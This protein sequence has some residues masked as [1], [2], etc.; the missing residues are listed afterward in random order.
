MAVGPYFNAQKGE[1]LIS[2]KRVCNSCGPVSE[3]LRVVDEKDKEGVGDMQIQISN[4][5]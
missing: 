3:T 2:S 5:P 4:L 1:I